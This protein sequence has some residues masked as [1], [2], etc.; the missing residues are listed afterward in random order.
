VNDHLARRPGD[1]SKLIQNPAEKVED[2]RPPRAR[3]PHGLGKAL[4]TH[5]PGRRR[6]RRAWRSRWDTHSYW[7]WLHA[8]IV[9]PW[10]QYVQRLKLGR[11]PIER[12]LDG[13]C[14]PGDIR[15]QVSPERQGSRAG[16]S[17]QATVV[18]QNESGARLHRRWQR[19]I[20]SSLIAC[21]EPSDWWPTTK[22]GVAR[23]VILSSSGCRRSAHTGRRAR[24][25]PRIRCRCRCRCF[26]TGTSSVKQT[27]K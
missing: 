1:L 13:A 11:G 27:G 18:V 21:F 14:R 15:R 20:R 3:P 23:H 24:R 22:N 16:A 6:R 25:R 12:S 26:P 19:H 2:P 4:G 8:S 9:P 10:E 5:P 17:M 7:K